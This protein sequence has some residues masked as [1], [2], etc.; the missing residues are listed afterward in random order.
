MEER[1]SARTGDETA[2]ITKR[3]VLDRIVL[4]KA[5]TEGGAWLRIS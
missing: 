4:N 5:I 1:V 3:S 2:D